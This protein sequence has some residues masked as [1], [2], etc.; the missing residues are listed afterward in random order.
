LDILCLAVVGFAGAAL[1]G[2]GISQAIEHADLRAAYLHASGPLAW[3]AGL[4]RLS[5]STDA[6]S[7]LFALLLAQSVFGLLLAAFARGA[8]T[9]LVLSNGDWLVACQ[10]ALV[11]LPG[12]VVGTLIHSALIGFGAVSVNAWLTAAGNDLSTVGQTAV[13]VDG[14]Q[15]L[16]FL[17]SLDALMPNP[18]SPVSEFVPHLRHTAFRHL[19]LVVDYNQQLMLKYN[20]AAPRVGTVFA[21]SPDRSR[22]KCIWLLASVLA[23]VIGGVVLRFWAVM[24]MQAQTPYR[25]VVSLVGNALRSVPSWRAAESAPYNATLLLNAHFVSPL[26][27]TAVF[28]I[29]HFGVIAVHAGVLHLAAWAF[30]VTFVVVP[31]VIVQCFGADVLMRLGLPRDLISLSAVIAGTALVSSL[32]TAFGVVY[33]ARL[34]L[35]LT[36]RMRSE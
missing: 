18:G 10:M 8:I 36:Q 17:R 20:G 11:R 19:E 29:R 15:R 25:N 24:M 13:T 32:Y 1:I 30:G 28:G 35:A 9:R 23:W 27:R 14:A 7:G 12:L 2:L 21:S 31:V 6:G 33:D 26:A 3:H 22:E 34:Y 4:N 16:A 5:P